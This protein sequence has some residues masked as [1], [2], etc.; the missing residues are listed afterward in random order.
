MNCTAASPGV[1]ILRPHRGS[2]A[3]GTDAT[4]P[5]P[6]LEHA[7]PNR[8]ATVCVRMDVPPT[9]TLTHLRFTTGAQKS[10]PPFPRFIKARASV[11]IN[12]PVA[13]YKPRAKTSNAIHAPRQQRSRTDIAH[14]DPKRAI[15]GHRGRNWKSDIRRLVAVSTNP[16]RRFFPPVV[17]AISEA[18]CSNLTFIA[19]AP[20]SVRAVARIRSKHPL[21]YTCTAVV[22]QRT[23][24]CPAKGWQEYE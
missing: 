13:F 10:L 4:T 12:A 16:V 8:A 22:G 6:S 5:K 18:S 17:S 20:E 23:Q 24:E 19:C 3:T 14:T 7:R 9:A 11:P 15:E 2:R 1:S 21:R